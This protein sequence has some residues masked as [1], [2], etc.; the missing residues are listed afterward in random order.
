[1]F[2]ILS[3]I[4]AICLRCSP[5]NAVGLH[6]YEK[7]GFADIGQAQGSAVPLRLLEKNIE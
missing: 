7:Y 5:D 1:M 4:F 3:W 6:F 2:L